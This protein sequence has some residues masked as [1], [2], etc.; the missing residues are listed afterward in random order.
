MLLALNAHLQ[1]AYTLNEE[2]H[3]RDII[4]TGGIAADRLS[5][6]FIICLKEAELK[7][8]T[9]AM[10]HVWSQVTGFNGIEQSAAP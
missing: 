2:S 8:E 1:N 3:S 10:H 6:L 9:G 7:T 4:S 5:K